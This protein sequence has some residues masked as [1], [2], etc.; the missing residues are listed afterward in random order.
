MAGNV[1]REQ[2][3]WLYEVVTGGKEKPFISSEPGSEGDVAA[4]FLSGLG[5]TLVPWEIE[6]SSVDSPSVTPA[7]F[8][9][10]SLSITHSYRPEN[11]IPFT[12]YIPPEYRSN[13]EDDWWWSAQSCS[14]NTVRFFHKWALASRRLPRRH[15]NLLDFCGVHRVRFPNPFLRCCPR[16]GF[17][18]PIGG[19]WDICFFIEY[20]K[21]NAPSLPHIAVGASQPVEAREN[22][23]LYGELAVILAVM[24]GRASQPKA[25]S[26][27][28]MENIHDMQRQ[29][30]EEACWNS[31]AFPNEQNFPLLLFS[32]V[33]PQHARILCASM[34][35]T[36]LIV[37]MSKLYSFERKEEAPLEL[38]TSWLF[39]RSVVNT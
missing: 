27:E 38:F 19:R 39:S 3:R 26:E 14:G 18:P 2:V 33:G 28:E 11:D 24:K 30:L 37:R 13:T 10:L 15:T 29:E 25:E 36:Q 12:D 6:T 20:E 17:C 23:I 9:P 5:I 35:Q 34:D 4:S 32:F 1:T 21:Q 22:F 7:P 16:M 8:T 31:P